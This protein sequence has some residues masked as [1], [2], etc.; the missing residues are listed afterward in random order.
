M[1]QKIVEKF[2]ELYLEVGSPNKRLS[3]TAR[4]LIAVVVLQGN[5][6]K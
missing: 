4:T 2:P 6:E 3:L 5:A 1:Q